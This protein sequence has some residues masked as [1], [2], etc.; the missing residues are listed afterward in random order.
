MASLRKLSKAFFRAQAAW[1]KDLRLAARIAARVEQE[2]L[3]KLC[4]VEKAYRA[5]RVR[6][7]LSDENPNTVK[8]LAQ[9][10]RKKAK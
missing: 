10:A 5:E 6:R 9:R 7:G 4:A 2:S 1:Q 8:F 3:A